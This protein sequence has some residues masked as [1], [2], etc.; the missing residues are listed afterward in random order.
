MCRLHWFTKDDHRRRALQ[1]CQ[2]T[3]NC[4]KFVYRCSQSLYSLATRGWLVD[5]LLIQLLHALSYGPR[6]DIFVSY[7]VRTLENCDSNNARF[8]NNSRHCS[9]HARW[10]IYYT[11]NCLT[12]FELQETRTNTVRR[13][14]Q[15]SSNVEAKSNDIRRNIFPN[16]IELAYSCCDLQIQLQFKSQWLW[17]KIVPN[18]PTQMYHRHTAF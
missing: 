9:A 14:A 16:S 2:L 13:M 1:K 17:S 18:Y 3:V 4:L 8:E 11:T 15:S 7:L 12:P 5:A 6:S 10:P